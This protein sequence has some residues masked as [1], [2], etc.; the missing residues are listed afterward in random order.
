MAML[1]IVGLH[2]PPSPPVEVDTLQ[3]YRIPRRLFASAPF[4][5]N[6]NHELLQ[7]RGTQREL[8][9]G[10]ASFGTP[11]GMYVQYIYYVVVY[12]Y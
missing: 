5:A 8:M 3:R 10:D 11:P 7:I 2:T 1:G 12:I 6:H 9:G 4:H